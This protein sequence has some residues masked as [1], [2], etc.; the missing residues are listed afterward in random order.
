MNYRNKLLFCLCTILGGMNIAVAA[1]ETPFAVVGEITAGKNEMG[2][3]P[4][5]RFFTDMMID[6]SLIPTLSMST[7]Q[8]IRFIDPWRWHWRKWDWLRGFVIEIPRIPFPE[9]DPGPLLV[10]R[11]QAVYDDAQDMIMPMPNVPPLEKGSAFITEL[12]FPTDSAF[13]KE[14]RLPSLEEINEGFKEGVFRVVDPDG[15]ELMN[16]RVDALKA[17]PTQ[18]V[19]KGDLDGDGDVDQ[20]DVRNLRIEFNR[21][22]CPLM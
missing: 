1:D 21:R 8:W 11:I 19:C 20:S 18:P 14:Q 10:L 17:S 9:P 5:E 4:G 22:N 3:E 7:P 2:V 6:P 12:S 13:I 16:G 15:K